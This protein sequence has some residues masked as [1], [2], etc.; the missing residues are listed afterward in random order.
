MSLVL[1]RVTAPV[2]ASSWLLSVML[3]VSAV[4]LMLLACRW[5]G[6]AKVSPLLLSG[7]LPSMLTIPKLLMFRVLLGLVVINLPMMLMLPVASILIPL[8]AVMVS[9]TNSP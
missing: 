2:L 5:E 1:V 6:A 8:P 7:S 4:M 3:M 9:P